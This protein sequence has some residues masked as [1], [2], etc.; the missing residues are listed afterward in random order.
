DRV[1]RPDELSQIRAAVE[2]EPAAGPAL[3]VDGSEARLRRQVVTVRVDVLAEER[4]L[5]VPG[6]RERSRLVDDLVE[7]AT[8]LRPAA[9]R[10]DAVRARLVAAV[11][12]RQPG[13]DR[14]LAGN[15]AAGDG[16]RAGPRQ[17][18]RRAHRRPP[19]DRGRRA[20]EPDGALRRCQ[21]EPV[22]EL[23][24]LVGPQE[25]VDRREALAEAGA[26]PLADGAAGQDDPHARVRGLEPGELALPA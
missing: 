19:D 9:E 1:D 13:A 26:I 12:D 21:P 22:D 17:V 24:L 2:V 25:E 20:R 8:S 16:R 14:G 3:G 5:A 7:R 4:D 23:R 6:G 18:I 10:D 11:D 15:R